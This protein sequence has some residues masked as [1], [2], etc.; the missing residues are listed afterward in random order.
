[1]IMNTH[2]PS[3]TLWEASGN[4]HQPVAARIAIAGDFLPAGKLALNPDSNWCHKALGV[5]PYFADVATTFANLEATLDTESLAPRPLIGLGQIVS[6]PAASLA[7]LH[8]IHARAVGVANNHT[9]DFGQAGVQRTR[10]AIWRQG[11]TPLGAGQST[12]AQPEIFIWQG[13][14][15]L[16]VGFWAAAKATSD[17]ATHNT[18]GV[19]PAAALRGLQALEEMERRGAHLRIAL[20]H[21]GCMRTNRP[22][23]EDVRLLELLAKSGFD[24][25]A[26]SHSHR[27]SG[28]RRIA[29]PQNRQSFC[30]YGLGSLAS[31]FV[32]SPEERE[33]LIVVA[34][35]SA[36]GKMVNLEVRPVLIG[37]SGFSQI[38]ADKNAQA[39]L[40][41]FRDLSA[42]IEDGSYRKLFY[43]DAS[44]GM[45]K[46]YLRDARAAFRTAGI[47][48]LA[49]KA[50]RVRLRHVKRLVHKVM[51]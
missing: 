36:A 6:A 9:Y 16:R 45:A 4:A 24:I 34:G 5:A 22:D 12:S 44:Q 29:R 28:Y 30:F 7:Y 25:V 13:P 51:G 20:L 3:L 37:D 8:A 14:C 26:A 10:H 11:M 32:A 43:H 49:H 18:P 17:P 31:G 38:P 33:G 35:L 47:R 46:L 1:M 41:R 39:I 15:G 21:A 19:E 50:S 40:Q 48:G 2:T 27:I 42:E 23:P